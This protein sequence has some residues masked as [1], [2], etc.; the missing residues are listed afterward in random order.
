MI[1]NSDKRLIS[2]EKSSDKKKIS[3]LKNKIK[4]YVDLLNKGMPEPSLGDCWVCAS[5]QQSCLNSHLNEG[6]IHGTLLINALQDEG[7]NDINIQRMF[8]LNIKSI[9]KKALTKYL[10]KYLITPLILKVK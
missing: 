3:I 10:T 2:K 5:N 9:F 4:N 7:R 8:Q 6:Y 1:F